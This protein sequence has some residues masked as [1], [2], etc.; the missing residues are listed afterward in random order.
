MRARVGASARKFHVT[1]FDE[2]DTTSAWLVMAVL[3]PVPQGFTIRGLVLH[4]RAKPA[5]RRMI[6]RIKSIV[7]EVFARGG[8]KFP[9]A[10]DVVIGQV[11]CLVRRSPDALRGEMMLDTR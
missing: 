5:R 7:C 4:T 6:A 2:H 8:D 3:E 10:D 9:V 11:R 1:W